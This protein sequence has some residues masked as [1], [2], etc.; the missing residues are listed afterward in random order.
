MKSYIVKRPVISE[1]SLELANSQNVYTF[2][3]AKEAS[4]NQ[5]KSAVEEL[6][7]VN[8]I[9]LNTITRHK[10]LKRTGR[11]RLSVMAPAT[12]K[13]LVKLKQG[14][15]IALFDLGGND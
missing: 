10:E 15:T 13:A 12:K 2:M 11:K 9:D 14:Q 8:V 5:V 3:V 4:K 1:K 6:F 7:G